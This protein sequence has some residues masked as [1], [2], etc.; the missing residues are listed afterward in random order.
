MG[1]PQVVAFGFTIEKDI[2][3]QSFYE[4][5]TLRK[6]FTLYC[7]NNRGH[8]KLSPFEV[9]IAGISVE[10]LWTRPTPHLTSQLCTDTSISI[11]DR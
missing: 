8:T 11:S 3:F 1:S 6:K 2:E 5:K 10:M 7:G 4:H 9:W